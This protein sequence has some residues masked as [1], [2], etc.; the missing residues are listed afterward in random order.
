[1]VKKEKISADDKAGT[2]GRIITST[3][4]EGQASRADLVVEAATEN[5]DLQTQDIQGSG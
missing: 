2:L 4:M 5:L 3:D 1:M